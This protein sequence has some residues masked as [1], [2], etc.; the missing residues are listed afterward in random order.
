MSEVEP[1]E[2]E[3]DEFK[4]W[5]R[6]AM[7]GFA[8]LC[9]AVTVGIYRVERYAGEASRTADEVDTFATE[10]RDALVESCAE[11]INPA[12][13]SVRGVLQD[14]IRQSQNTEVLR[15][16]FPTI[17]PAELTK[18]LAEANAERRE[19]I[20]ELAPLDCVGRYPEDE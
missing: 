11:T 12:L 6:R 15:R 9:L 16:F 19:S 17:S 13:A 7:I 3:V 14:Q 20:R 2:E 10:L 4:L 18:L 8:G 5:R 1:V